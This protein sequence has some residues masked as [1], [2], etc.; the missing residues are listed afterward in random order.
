MLFPLETLL[1][2][3]VSWLR[4]LCRIHSSWIQVD[5]GRECYCSP[6][7]TQA[8]CLA[9]TFIVGSHFGFSC[10]SVGSTAVWI[11]PITITFDIG[12]CLR[13]SVCSVIVSSEVFFKLGW[14]CWCC[15]WGSIL[16]GSFLGEVAALPLKES[17][18]SFFSLLLSSFDCSAGRENISSV[19]NFMHEW[20]YNIYNTPRSLGWWFLFWIE[21]HSRTF[22]VTTLHHKLM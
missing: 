17:T 15:C 9:E 12:D 2:Q 5:G 11:V 20:Y 7:T 14:Y 3:H 10:V 21:S 16:L 19:P 13:D 8:S 18:F 4:G 22:D 6:E 1:L